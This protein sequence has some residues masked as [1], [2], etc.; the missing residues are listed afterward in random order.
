MQT[1]NFSAEC[2]Q[3]L[4]GLF[5]FTTK[6]G[7]N[8]LHGSMYDYLTNEALD[9]CQPFTGARPLSRPTPESF[10]GMSHLTKGPGGDVLH[11]GRYTLFRR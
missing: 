2:G 1:A 4:G 7:T 9:S 5:N 6:S 3:V 8:E 11:H 10:R